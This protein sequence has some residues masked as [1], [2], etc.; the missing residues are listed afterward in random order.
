MSVQFFEAFGAPLRVLRLFAAQY[1]HLPAPSVDM[2]TIYPDRLTLSF[3]EDL[4]GFEAWRDALSIA[5]DAVGHHVHRNG[6][7]RVLTAETDC[8]GA[9]LHLVGFATV[10]APDRERSRAGGVA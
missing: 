2:S 8:A 7:T 9:E 1:P 10:P 5:P 6:R 4:A 3:H